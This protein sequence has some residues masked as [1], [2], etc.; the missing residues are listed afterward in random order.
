MDRRHQPSPASR[1]HIVLKTQYRHVKYERTE[2]PER[3]C[4]IRSDS[5]DSRI[6]RG[7][8]AHRKNDVEQTQ[9]GLRLLHL[10]SVHRTSQTT[11]RLCR[12]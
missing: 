6:N 10:A 8:I 11:D 7:A 1:P 2:M 4:P 3:F 12:G 9:I 5:V